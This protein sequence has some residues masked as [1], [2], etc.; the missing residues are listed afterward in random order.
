M[1]N[2]IKKKLIK[3]RLGE[4]GRY[5]EEGDTL[6]QFKENIK[7]EYC[8]KS[9]INDYILSCKDKVNRI[10]KIED[11]KT[12]QK[13]KKFIIEYP[14]LIQPYFSPK[15]ITIHNNSKCSECSISPIIGIKYHCMK[16][17]LYELCSNCE[18]KYG[19]KHGHPLLKLRK[20]DYL[21]KYRDEIFKNK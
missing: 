18:M 17:D 3:V 21:E 20:A 13:M 6:E 2:D 9:S 12:Y 11:E 1:K 8:I 14:K 19:E 5:I 10:T 7:I 4:E 16:C 15:D